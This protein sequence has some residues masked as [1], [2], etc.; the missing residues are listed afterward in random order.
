MDIEEK[1]K[2]ENETAI[3]KQ[4]KILG[5]VD[6]ITKKF[7]YETM[8]CMKCPI[9]MECDHS[10]KHIEVLKEEAE[11]H[12]QAVYDEELEL[13]RSAENVLRA[14]KR[15]QEI[16]DGYIR[17]NAG[18]TLAENR[19][20]YEEQ[21]ILTSLEKF[22]D[23]GYDL[24]DPRVYLIVNELISNILLAGRANKA[25]TNLGMVLRKDTPGGPVF[26]NNPVLRYR[27]EFSKMIM[28][29]TEALDRMLKSDESQNATAKFTE[30]MIS[31][32]NMRTK[33]KSLGTTVLVE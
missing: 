24:A 18:R 5:S 6:T 31:M 12:G 1:R 19:C 21:E 17:D 28:E 3:A 10:V 9:V 25:F 11:M 14:Q 29:S 22:V 26:Y 20:I 32:L 16:Y 30:H 7:K 33:K 15:R 27:A 8:R 2:E 23:A 13:D 4:E